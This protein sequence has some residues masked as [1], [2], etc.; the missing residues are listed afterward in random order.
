[1]QIQ[2]RRRT[3]YCAKSRSIMKQVHCLWTKKPICQ[4]CWISNYN[5]VFSPFTPG[6]A[7]TQCKHKVEGSTEVFDSSTAAQVPTEPAYFNNTT[8]FKTKLDIQ[9]LIGEMRSAVVQFN[10]PSG[11]PLKNLVRFWGRDAAA[12]FQYNGTYTQGHNSAKFRIN[13]FRPFVTDDDD[14]FKHIVEV[15]H[16][17]GDKFAFWRFFKKFQELLGDRV[18]HAHFN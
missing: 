6:E 10:E 11:S 4:A 1:M 14:Q 12:P 16:R 17:Y 7:A 15:Q 13:L 5:Q 8:S 18:V 9:S 3:I 2:N